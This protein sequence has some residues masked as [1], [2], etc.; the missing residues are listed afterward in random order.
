MNDLARTMEAGSAGTARPRGEATLF[1]F[2]DVADRLHERVAQAMTRVGLSFPKF[3]VLKHLRDAG[4]PMT[5]G[6]LAEGQSCARSN[7]TQLVDR[8]E[9]EGLVRRVA[10]PKDRRSVRAELTDAGLAR[11]VEGETQLDL[12]RAEFAASL[13]A[14]ERSELGRLLEKLE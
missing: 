4:E 7:I 1:T 11:L 14:P 2:L 9:S 5:L 3:E 10:D 6:C 12:V 8:L 13:S